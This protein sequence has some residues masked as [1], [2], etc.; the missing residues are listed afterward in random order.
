MDLEKMGK[1]IAEMRKKHSLTQSQLGEML[2]ISGK[3]ISKWERG[4]SAPD[5]S[6]LNDL[7]KILE[8]SVSEILN[9]E[10][11]ISEDKAN[12]VNVKVIDAYNKIFK[13]KYTKV[14]FILI[15]LLLSLIILFSVAYLITNYNK[16]FVYKLSSGSEEFYLEGLIA[17]NQK[18]NSLLITGISYYGEDYQ[19]EDA[20]K[21]N[22]IKTEVMINQKVIG[23]TIKMLE[24][25]SIEKA[26]ND[27][28]LIV[29]ENPKITD[30]I[31]KKNI[32]NIA[33]II[34]LYGQ[35]DLKEKYVIPLKIEKKFSNNRLVY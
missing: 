1:F 28:Y 9:G 3:A 19:S 24:N 23:R 16:C 31:I 34:T 5:I 11:D 12:N 25:D 21:Y 17:S 18:E 8:V 2:G 22:K 27:N 35:D 6:L 14:I 33:I 10:K 7:S 32:K 15:S 26:L 4:I 30:Y 20:K 29:N 13:K